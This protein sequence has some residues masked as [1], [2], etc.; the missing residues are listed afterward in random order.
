MII[1]TGN[2]ELFNGEDAVSLLC[3]LPGSVRLHRG[4][5]FERHVHYG[6][7][8][9]WKLSCFRVLCLLVPKATQA[10]QACKQAGASMRQCWQG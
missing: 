8:A 9:F 2:T 3:C 5:A 7:E 1:E 6:E 4:F 10:Y